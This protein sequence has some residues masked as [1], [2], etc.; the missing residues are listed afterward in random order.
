MIGGTA[1]AKAGFE[2]SAESKI[3]KAAL[4]ELA[5]SFGADVSQLIVDVDGKVVELKG[6]AEAQFQQ[7]RQLLRDIV[8]TEEALP[9]DINV[10][11]VPAPPAEDPAPTPPLPVA[12]DPGAAASPQGS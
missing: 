4:E 2:N 7:W 8:F 6:S 10:T 9:G 3:H 1:L 11:T 5:E 12:A